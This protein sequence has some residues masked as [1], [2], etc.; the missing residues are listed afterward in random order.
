AH[1]ARR[2]QRELVDLAV[3]DQRMAGVVAALKAHHDVGPLGQ[4]VD[5]LAF[6]FVAPLGADHH[7]VR[8]VS[9]PLARGRTAG[10]YATALAR[11]GPPRKGESAFIA[12]DAC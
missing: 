6:T 7:Y 9:K 2:Q 10:S 11:A 1:H 5:D 8:H 12:V 4:P 3:D